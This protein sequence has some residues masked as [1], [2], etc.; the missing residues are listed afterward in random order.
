MLYNLDTCTFTILSCI[1]FNMAAQT[2]PPLDELQFRNPQIIE[3]HVQQMGGQPMDE[4][5]NPTPAHN[6]SHQ[7]TT[8]HTY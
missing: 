3:W 4:A 6:P 1:T 2:Q 5:R 7:T 8:S